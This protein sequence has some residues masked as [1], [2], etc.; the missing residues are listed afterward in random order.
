M[1]TMDNTV[2]TLMLCGHGLGLGGPVTTGVVALRPQRWGD[3]GQSAIDV[4]GDRHRIAPEQEA[5]WLATWEL[6]RTLKKACETSWWR[7]W[8]YVKWRKP[9]MGRKMRDFVDLQKEYRVLFEETW[10]RADAER[11]DGNL[12]G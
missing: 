7:W 4:I 2:P 10:A 11:K 3:F 12:E 5:V 1:T 9:T 8:L 6:D